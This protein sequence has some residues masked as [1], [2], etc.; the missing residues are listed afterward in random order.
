MLYKNRE[1][2][3]NKNP[4]IE[5]IFLNDSSVHQKGLEATSP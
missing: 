2:N 3:T 4:Y 1:E 5:S